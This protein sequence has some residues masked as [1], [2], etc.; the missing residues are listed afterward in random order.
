[1]K[2]VAAAGPSGAVLLV[3]SGPGGAGKS[4]LCERLVASSD[5][6]E[7]SISTTTREPR[8]GERDGVHYFFTTRDKFE[9]DAE[10][11]RFAEHAE[12]A[13]H[14]YGT[15]REFLDVRL[16]AGIDV[17]L[18]IDVQGARQVREAYGQTAVLVFVVPPDSAVLEQRL[19]GRRTDSEERIAERMAL[20]EREIAAARSGGYDYLV[21]NGALEAA[22]EE[23]GA[24]LRAEHGRLTRDGSRASWVLRTWT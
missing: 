19:R 11:G 23:L 15:P 9:A 20:A 12:V 22:L 7:L 1:L 14:L 3:V 4:T 18:D 17:V 8:G 5:E 21:I 24:I 10:A 13:G 2:Q 6:A 16:R